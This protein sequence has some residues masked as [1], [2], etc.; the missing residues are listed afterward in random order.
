MRVL[1]NTSTLVQI[2]YPEY[3]GNRLYQTLGNLQVTAR[4]GIVIP[5]FETGDAI[6]ATCE[7]Q[8]LVQDQAAALIP[9]SNLVV[10]FTLNDVRFV[11]NCLAFRASD[12][13]A[14][15]YNPPVRPLAT[16][17]A[18]QTSP[19]EPIAIATL[20]E[21]EHLTDDVAYLRF[22]TNIPVSWKPG[23]HVGLSFET[24][25]GTGYAHMN[26]EDPQSLN[27]DLVRN[28]TVTSIPPRPGTSANKFELLVRKV[29]KVTNHLQKANIRAEMSMPV[30]GFGGDFRIETENEVIG[31]FAGGV[32]ITPLLGQLEDLKFNQLELWWS[33]NARDLPIVKHIVGGWKQL[34]TIMLFV[35]GSIPQNLEGHLEQLGRMGIVIQ[36]RRISKN[37]L[38][39]TDISKWYMCAGPALKREAEEWLAGKEIISEDFNY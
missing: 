38:G 9:R 17:K 33:V 36:K 2:A 19:A 4:A 8:I 27:D 13:E 10:V 12:V 37:D 3:S 6:Y 35:S 25:L 14:S 1:S 34:P 16:E 31:F 39:A 7:T 5:D 29:G 11:R 20:V 24:E 21:R 32:G 18:E 28:F 22:R 15:P 23:Q 30:L 26:N